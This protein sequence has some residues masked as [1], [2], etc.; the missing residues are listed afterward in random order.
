[1][2]IPATEVAQRAAF[3]AAMPTELYDYKIVEVRAWR[4]DA[5]GGAAVV[6]TQHNADT[7][8]TDAGPFCTHTLEWWGNAVPRGWDLHTTEHEF[9]TLAAA[10]ENA[11][12]RAQDE[13][14]YLLLCEWFTMCDNYAAGAVAHP[15]LGMVPTCERC[16]TMHSM[17]LVP[18]G[19]QS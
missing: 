16:A 8:A 11:R 9:S 10:R 15:T 17:T 2:T 14:M 3:L 12:E 5:D 1:M 6:I 13:A 19:V 18:F 7:R 4:P